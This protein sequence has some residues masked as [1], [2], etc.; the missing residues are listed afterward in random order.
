MP[1]SSSL[2]KKGIGYR[3]KDNAFVEIDDPE[4]LQE[5]A[6]GLNGRLVLNRI[7][8]WSRGNSIKQYNKTGYFL[9]TDRAR[10]A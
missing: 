8:H 7:K 5:I 9:R 4:A 3:M 10:L 6:K 2:D 1:F